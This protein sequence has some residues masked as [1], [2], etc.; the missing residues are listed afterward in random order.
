MRKRP[1]PRPKIV[2]VCTNCREEAANRPSC[3]PRGG[4]NLRE[5]LKELVK[6][7]RLR[8]KIRVSQSGCMDR[9]E[10]GPNIMVFPDNVWYSNVLPE[11]LE[12]I[13][14]EIAAPFERPGAKQTPSS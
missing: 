9:C 1:L 11:D 14:D 3:G 10:D 12:A 6:Q 8:S 7:R 2:F 13:L 4:I 5:Q